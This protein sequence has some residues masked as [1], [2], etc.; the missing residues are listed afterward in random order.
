MSKEG[1][2]NNVEERLVTL[3]QNFANL[4]K[5]DH[6]REEELMLELSAIEKEMLRVKKLFLS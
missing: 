3:K 2:L 5:T 1:M 6:E 4:D